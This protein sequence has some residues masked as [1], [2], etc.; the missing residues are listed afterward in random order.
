MAGIDWGTVSQSFKATPGYQLYTTVAT[1]PLGC[2]IEE[3][4]DGD[5]VEIT[6]VVEDG[7]GA[8]AGKSKSMSKI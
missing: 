4:N 7:G 2:D 8:R 1:F 5:A 6:A 3:K